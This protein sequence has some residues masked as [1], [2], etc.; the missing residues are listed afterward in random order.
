LQYGA[1]LEDEVVAKFCDQTGWKHFDAGLLR[2]PVHDFLGGSPDGLLSSAD[3]TQFALLEIKCPYRKTIVDEISGY[4]FPQIRVLCRSP[5]SLVHST[6]FVADETSRTS[7][8]ICQC[9]SVRRKELLK[10]ETDARVLHVQLCMEICDADSCWFVQY[11]PA[12]NFWEDEIMS[13]IEV[14]RDREWFAEILPKARAFW[15]DVLYYREHMSELLA[16]VEGKKRKREPTGR[17]ITL[18]VP[19]DEVRVQCRID[20]DEKE[21]ASDSRGA[22]WTMPTQCLIDV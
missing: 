6:A 20:L 5:D 21:V 4:Y 8:L 2:H 11:R 9:H 16:I 18:D 10:I 14:K 3:G 1:S 17:T 12:R 15:D 7:N 13:V 19:S 22:A